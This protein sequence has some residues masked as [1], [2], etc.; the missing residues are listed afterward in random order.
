MAKKVKIAKKEEIKHDPVREALLK[1]VAFFKNLSKTKY[2]NYILYGLG[3]ILVIVIA[4]VF[5]K[6]STKPRVSYEADVY[7]LQAIYAISSQDTIQAPA[8]LDS[9]TTKFSKSTSGMRALYYAGVYY[10]K[11]GDEK[12]AIRYFK[13]FLSTPLNDKLLRTFTYS[14]LSDIYMD[15]KKSGTALYY[16]KKAY[17]NAPNESLKAYYYYKLAKLYYLKGNIEKSKEMLA[18]FEKKFPKSAIKSA[19]NEE[20]NF[21]KGIL[22]EVN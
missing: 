11:R 1:V 5:Y 3:G 21:M 7:L 9:L 20:L 15:M 6:N 19:I 18:S 14:Q 10:L 17:R 13:K 4:W 16:M 22:G 12:T 8:L 2:F